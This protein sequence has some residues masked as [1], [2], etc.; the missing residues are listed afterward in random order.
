MPPLSQPSRGAAVDPNAV[1]SRDVSKDDRD[2]LEAALAIAS[3]SSGLDSVPSPSNGFV[4]E[5]GSSGTAR[6]IPHGPKIATT[7]AVVTTINRNEAV[8]VPVPVAGSTTKRRRKAPNKEK[9]KAKGRRVD[10]DNKLESV[11]GASK[12]SAV[13]LNT[14]PVQAVVSTNDSQTTGVSQLPSPPVGVLLAVPRTALFS[15]A[16]TGLRYVSPLPA[17]QGQAQHPVIVRGAPLNPAVVRPLHNEHLVAVQQTFLTKQ[18]VVPHPSVLT[19]MPATREL[20]QHK[21]GEM[22][23]SGVTVVKLGSSGLPSAPGPSSALCEPQTAPYDLSLKKKTSAEPVLISGKQDVLLGVAGVDAKVIPRT[24]PMSVPAVTPMEAKVMPRTVPMSVPA[25]TPTEAKVMPRTVPISVPAVTPTEAKVMRWTVP[26]SVS[27]VTPTDTKVMP[28]TVPMSVPAVTPMEAK[29]MPRT[30]PMS[31][32]AVMPTDTK[33]M[34]QT[35]P[36]SVPAVT[37]M[38]TKVMP[39]TALA[40]HQTSNALSA[41]TSP[42]VKGTSSVSTQPQKPKRN[43]FGKKKCDKQ[44]SDLSTAVVPANSVANKRVASPEQQREH[45][46]LLK[47]SK[48]TTNS[49]DIRKLPPKK[50]KLYAQRNEATEPEAAV[51]SVS[52]ATTNIPLVVSEA[53][54]ATPTEVTD[55][56]QRFPVTVKKENSGLAQKSNGGS[57]KRSQTPKTERVKSEIRVPPAQ[58]SGAVKKGK[59]CDCV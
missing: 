27:A 7:S 38:D 42:S 35:V 11:A 57:P 13:G 31:V 1:K 5:R 24:V 23:P 26:M 47:T 19:Y 21:S 22:P 15:P 3:L 4:T 33:V 8:Q 12:A 44:P 17:A 2:R 50:R 56:L 36:M 14:V 18:A 52:M 46:A 30:V 29:V 20:R 48:V 10:Q 58:A 41:A 59:L 28:G 54:V 45:T 55:V 6:V 51:V 53:A 37:P 43:Q 16:D 39:Q 34:P 40:S 9:P 32:P 49:V 25:V